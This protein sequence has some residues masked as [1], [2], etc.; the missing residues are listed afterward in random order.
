MGGGEDNERG[1]LRERGWQ[2]C[3]LVVAQVQ[4]VELAQRK[5]LRR[6]AAFANAVV[7]QIQHLR[8]T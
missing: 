8:E 3:Q 2:V 4:R 7:C 1:E 6:N 5:Q